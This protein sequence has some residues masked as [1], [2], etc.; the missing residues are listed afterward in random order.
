MTSALS[1]HTCVYVA[2]FPAI[3]KEFAANSSL[4]GPTSDNIGSAYPVKAP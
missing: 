1:E 2:D 4:T 3:M